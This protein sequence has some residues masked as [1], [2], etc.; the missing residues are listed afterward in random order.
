MTTSSEAL[1]AFP[2]DVRA[3]A[4]PRSRA[5][6][7]AAAGPVAGLFRPAV[8]EVVDEAG[9]LR[10]SLF[11]E[12]V[13]L[14]LAVAAAR[15]EI[16]RLRPAGEFRDSPIPG[17]TDELDAIVEHTASVTETILDACEQIDAVAETVGA[18][19][20][21]AIQEQT[22]LIFEACSFQDL[23]GRRIGKVVATLTMVE[24]RVARLMGLTARSVAGV[25]PPPP[26]ATRF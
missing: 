3:D 11:A 9:A 16:A 1:V 7:P 15:A 18:T 20:A 23:T 25:P 24:A 12:V 6:D 21:E 17:A 13:E 19:H 14:G 22:M 5:E 4:L 2:A 26:F 8:T 10:R